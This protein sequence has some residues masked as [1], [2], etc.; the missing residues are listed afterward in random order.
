MSKSVVKIEVKAVLPTNG[1]SAVFLGNDEKAFVIYIDDSIGA[2]I[3]M[4]M[5]QVPRER[6]QTHDLIAS[7]LKGLGAKVERVVIND[8]H[9]GVF[10][11]RLIISMENEL[12]Q[13]KIVELDARPSDSIAIACQVAAPLYVSDAVWESVADM[14]EMLKKVQ[15]GTQGHDDP[16]DL[17]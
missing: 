8:M 17:I 11:A 15:S 10:F 3:T 5:R 16:M 7:M 2:A 12:Y 9:E 13:R 4:A 6:P 1:G 14:S